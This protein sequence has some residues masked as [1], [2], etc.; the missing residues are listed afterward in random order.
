MLFSHS[1]MQGGGVFFSSFKCNTESVWQVNETFVFEFFNEAEY[2][3]FIFFF[4]KMSNK[5]MLQRG[6]TVP[7][8]PMDC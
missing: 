7:R 5:K 4:S 2:F 6:K 8:T 1:H 3:F